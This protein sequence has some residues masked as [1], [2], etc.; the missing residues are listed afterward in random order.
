MARSFATNGPL[1]QFSVNGHEA[2]DEIRADHGPVK[3]EVVATVESIVPMD[4]VDLIVNG[5]SV[6]RIALGADKFKLQIK[7]PLEL[8]ESAWVALR[9]HGPGHRLA[10][11]D[12]EVYAHTSPVYVTIGGR[13][14]AAPE[15]ARFFV[16]QI[17]ILIARMDQRG[18]FEN[19]A[20]RDELVRRFR[21]GQDVYRQLAASA[22]TPPGAKIP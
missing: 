7:E 21:E 9:V 8:A 3:L 14:V 6:K 18:V 13:P 19:R 4:A 11:N 15:D 12:R 22:A 10:P 16:E 17:D 2:G 5:R 20:Q 1:L